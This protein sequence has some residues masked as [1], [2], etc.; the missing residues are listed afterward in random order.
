MVDLPGNHGGNRTKTITRKI[1]ASP[2]EFRS[3]A[4]RRRETPRSPTPNV[5]PSNAALPGWPAPRG[6][7]PWR[8]GIGGHACRPGDQWLLDPLQLDLNL[9][10]RLRR[11]PQCPCKTQ[12]NSRK[13]RM[14]LT[15]SYTAFE[16]W[17]YLCRFSQT[18]LGAQHLHSPCC[19]PHTQCYSHSG[20]A[21]LNG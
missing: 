21:P 17:T 3:T 18:H 11:W 2:G 10:S 1:W 6:T 20:E 5:A 13:L 19:G 9:E 8:N 12:E 7:S 15:H 4:Q 16:S 14:Y